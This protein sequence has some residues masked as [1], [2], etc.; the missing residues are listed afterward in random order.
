MLQKKVCLLGSFAV[1]KTS[2]VSQY[3][4]SEFSEQYQTTIG[5]K[6]DRK[7]VSVDQQTVHLLLWDL[8]GDDEFQKVRGSYLRGMAGYFLVVDGTRPDTLEKAEQLQRLAEESVG[9]KPFL[10]LLNK[11]DLQDEWQLDSQQLGRFV[12]AGWDVRR[13]S[14][15]TGE[16]IEAAFQDLAAR[17]AAAANE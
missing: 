13:T 1:G 11:C 17:M 14:A 10:L 12:E 7:Q 8:H 2:L 16:N 15:K 4:Y 9:E 3:V 6:V 5:V